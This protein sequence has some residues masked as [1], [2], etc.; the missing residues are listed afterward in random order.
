M[1]I[2]TEEKNGA[3]AF[4][5]AGGNLSREIGRN[6]ASNDFMALSG[7]FLR[8]IRRNVEICDADLS[9]WICYRGTFASQR[10][11][12]TIVAR[13]PGETFSQFERRVA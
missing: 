4:S 5:R 9:A 8:H 3:S 12:S 10:V 1:I 6:T 7:L 13:N 11:H 2:P